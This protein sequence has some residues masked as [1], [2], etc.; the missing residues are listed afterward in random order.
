MCKTFV[1]AAPSRPRSF[2]SRW[3]KCQIGEGTGRL[4]LSG[5]RTCRIL[6]KRKLLFLLRNWFGRG[7]DEAPIKAK[8]LVDGH[9]KECFR[10]GEQSPSLTV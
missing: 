2:W 7:P 1:D 5:H 6:S 8:N 9:P 4:R 10:G 3:S